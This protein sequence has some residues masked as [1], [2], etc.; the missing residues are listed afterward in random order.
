MQYTNDWLESLTWTSTLSPA[1][2]L[3]DI[4]SKCQVAISENQVEDFIR[5]RAI[6]IVDHKAQQQAIQLAQ[7]VAMSDGEIAPIEQQA[8]DFLKSCFG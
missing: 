2:H 6:H 7:G 3:N 5:H 4:S 1:D 8:I